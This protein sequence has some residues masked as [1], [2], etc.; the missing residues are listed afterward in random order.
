MLEAR[1]DIRDSCWSGS[2]K[3]EME[4]GAVT[5]QSGGGGGGG[6]GGRVVNN[7][8]GAVQGQGAYEIYETTH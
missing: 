5:K 1:W 8:K 6:G 2:K 7:A 4:P 3:S